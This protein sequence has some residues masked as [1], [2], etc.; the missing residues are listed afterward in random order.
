MMRWADDVS[1]G[2]EATWLANDE[3][4]AP[5]IKDTVKAAHL[6]NMFLV[7]DPKNKRIGGNGIFGDFKGAATAYLPGP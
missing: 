6:P 7:R 4:Q 5:S 3:F 1:S 2:I